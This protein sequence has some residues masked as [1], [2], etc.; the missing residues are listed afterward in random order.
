ME[1]TI[2]A[3]QQGSDEWMQF[4]LQHHGASEAA[5]ML[6][7]SKNTTRNEL[8]HAKHTGLPKE[9]S[10]F[11][12]EKIL[13]HG[14]A[15]EAL[16][17]P[18]VEAMLGE[19]LYPATYAYGKLS[20][21]CDGLTMDGSTAFEH[22]QW[23]KE[24]AA[25]VARH[26]LPDEHMPQ[27]QQ[28]M[29]CTGAEL[30]MFV[31]SDGTA[32]NFVHM[33]VKPEIGW[34]ERIAK[35]WAQF[36]IDLAA[37]V[38]PEYIAAAVA[39]PIMALPAVM[40]KVEGS[41]ALVSNLDKFGEMLREF[42]AKIPKKPETDQQFADC[43]ASIAALQTAQDALDAAEAQALGQVAS[44]DEMKRAKALLWNLARDTRLSVEKMVTAQEKKVK[45]DIVIK[46]R[47]AFTAHMAKMNELIGR[48]YMPP[49]P[50]DFQGAIKGKRTIASLQNAVDTELAR[51]KIAASE[52]AAKIK[53]NMDTLQNTAAEYRFLFA[54]EAQIV[55]KA[56]DDFNALVELKIS[57]HKA[58]EQ[59]KADELR[60][61]IRK[62]EEAKAAQKVADEKAAAE[63]AARDLALAAAPKDIPTRIPE[64]ANTPQPPPPSPAAPAAA[65][66]RVALS[67]NGG[68]PRATDQAIIALVAN[69]YRVSE[70]TAI[71]WIGDIDI[72]AA[73]GRLEFAA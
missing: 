71:N 18:M 44:F 66:P 50:T 41:I 67:G 19:E 36:D 51:A 30:V 24:L 70:A 6:G 7:L 55:L 56:A 35:G 39:K 1:R 57:Q 49:V 54:D 22:K 13:D 47:D 40:I 48:P 11:V 2:Q 69:T 53:V 21:S 5:A 43:K 52:I 27:C 14:H 58:A 26:E 28:I 12:R 37:Y 42:V 32:E 20:A 4:R 10:D 17:R 9:F 3:L 23:A 72:Q 64:A 73:R 34:Q 16:A 45:E 68:R 33:E 63:Q 31:V 46:G 25:A 59:K 38:P 65:K 15:V 61:K 62:E 60:E 29:M 8:L